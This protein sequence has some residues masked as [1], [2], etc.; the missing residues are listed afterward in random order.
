[1]RTAERRRA[2]S[3]RSR[4]PTWSG[5]VEKASK[6]SPLWHWLAPSAETYPAQVDETVSSMPRISPCKDAGDVG[7]SGEVSSRSIVR[8]TS[9]WPDLGEARFWLHQLARR[10]LAR[11]A[12][13]LGVGVGVEACAGGGQRRHLVR[14]A[15]PRASG[16]EQVDVHAC[17]SRAAPN[18]RLARGHREAL[19]GA[20]AAQQA[21]R[22][23]LRVGQRSGAGEL[24]LAALA[25]LHLVHRDRVMMA[26]KPGC[27]RHQRRAGA[28]GEG[29]LGRR[30]RGEEGGGKREEGGARGSEE[31]RGARREE[32]L[33]GCWVRSRTRYA[34][35][36]LVITIGGGIRR[37]SM[38][39]SMRNSSFMPRMRR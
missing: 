29:E 15:N 12:A 6:Y 39:M 26:A 32:L 1:M 27:A 10:L 13:D 14:A 38:D 23:G 25:G 36:R 35:T 37:L 21:R 19:V 9:A 33:G 11:G 7:E 30:H 28:A 5:T 34:K 22:V 8:S 18:G 16:G 2:T 31:E 20:G 3:M 4:F 17:H 24:G